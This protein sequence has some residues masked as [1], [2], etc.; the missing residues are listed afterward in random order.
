MNAKVS[1][2]P[3]LDNFKRLSPQTILEFR[4]KGHTLVKNILSP[5]E[6]EA[7][8]P[9]IVN[10]ADRYNTE[11]RKLEERDTYGKAF[12]QI[13]NLW[14]V[15]TDT[16][17]FVFAP[18]MAKIAADLMGV[19][20]VRLYHDQALFK[21][22][23]G[24]PTP[25]HQDQYYWPVDTNNTVTMW[26]PLV[27]INEEMGMLTFA[28]N[29]YT[30]GAVFN[31]EISDQSAS[32]FDDYVTENNFPISRAKSM[33]AGDA[34]FHRGF[35]IHN[36]PGNNSGKRREIMTIIYVADGARITPHKNE[37]QKNDHQKWLMGKPIGSPV[38][39]E[40]N[41]KLL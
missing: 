12:L 8:R 11:K 10:A 25:W 39:S 14:Q 36:A 16:K 3:Q 32:A 5:A 20:N 15:D 19:E 34:T 38:D 13:M 18:R 24:G 4:E 1:P 17:K 2:L 40:L 33:K 6:I 37:W 28:S 35:T 30:N 23:G 41:P 27:D 29:S 7:Y 9:V 26:M 31:H 22:P 21:E